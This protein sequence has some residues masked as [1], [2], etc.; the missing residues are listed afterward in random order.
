MSLGWASEMV[1]SQGMD[2][3]PLMLNS[4]VPSIV[5]TGWSKRRGGFQG[6]Y[7]MELGKS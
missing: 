2:A 4:W 3:S 6:M 5:G 1:Q 7:D